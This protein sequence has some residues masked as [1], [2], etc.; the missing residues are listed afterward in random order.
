[1]TTG[2]L[3]LIKCATRATLFRSIRS[4]RF[5]LLR[6]SHRNS[7]NGDRGGP[8]QSICNLSEHYEIPLTEQ[9]SPQVTVWSGG[10]LGV[11]L[12]VESAALKILNLG[13]RE[14]DRTIDFAACAF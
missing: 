9:P 2:T 3:G 1:M 14:L 4:S 8:Q 7:E 12:H 13:R 10:T 11:N 6:D 5:G